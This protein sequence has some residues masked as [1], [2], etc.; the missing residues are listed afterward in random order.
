M[1]VG[2]CSPSFLSKKNMD[3]AAKIVNSAVL[4]MDFETAII[5]GKAYVIMP[6][7]IKKIAGAGYYLSDLGNG[8][9]MKDMIAS[10]P[11]IGNS[12]HAL[13]WFIQGDDSL[14]DEL[15]N[16]TLEEVTDALSK[17]VSMISAENFCKLSVLAR[18]VQ[19]LTAKA[20]L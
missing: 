19:N 6:P 16:G 9:T 14:Y 15:S 17:A 12:A 10:L 5:N 1:A 20:K 3:N 11:N 2:G 8:D 13:S 18:N 4:G 7:T